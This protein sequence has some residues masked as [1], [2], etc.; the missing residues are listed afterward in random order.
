M[1]YC[2]TGNINLSIKSI[3]QNLYLLFSLTL[4]L[5]RINSVGATVEE[6]NNSESGENE[7]HT[8]TTLSSGTYHTAP[9]SCGTPLDDGMDVSA[10]P[11]DRLMSDSGVELKG[12]SIK[13]HQE[14]SC[15]ELSSNEVMYL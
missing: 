4:N 5:K 15:D 9:N 14:E 11:F 1:F 6:S 3:L 2:G 12:S 10:A 13:N 7:N 8:V